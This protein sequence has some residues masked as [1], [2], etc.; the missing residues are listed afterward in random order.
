M[1]Q[2]YQA[3]VYVEVADKKLNPG[4]WEALCT[5]K[6][7]RQTQARE[8]YERAANLF[9]LEKKWF[10]AGEC[11]ERCASLDETLKGDASDALQEASHCFKQCDKKR[12][13]SFMKAPYKI[14]IRLS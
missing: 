11:Y 10:E 2:E 3:H 13:L 7:E 8:N 4:C 9:K 12:N 14:L 6:E 5:S 1:D